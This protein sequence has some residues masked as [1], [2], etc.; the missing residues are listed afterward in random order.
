MRRHPLDFVQVSYSAVE[1]DV[2]ARILPLARDR[3]IAVVI[4]RPFREGAL[5][6][7]VKRRPLPA[8]ASRSRL[9]QLGRVPVEVHRVASGGRLRDSRDD[10]RRSR[11]R[12]HGRLLR[13]PARRSR[14]A[15]GWPRTSSSSD[16]RVVDV[17]ALGLPALFARAPTTAS[18]SSTTPT[19]GRRRSSRSRSVSQ[20]LGLLR[21]PRAGQGRIVAAILAGCWLWVAWAF[22]WRHYATI[23]WAATYFAGAF[24]VEALLLVVIGVVRNDLVVRID[25]RRRRTASASASC[26][27]RS[28]VQPL[29]G[30][31][32]GRGWM[33]AEVFGVAPDP[34]VSRDARLPARGPRTHGVDAAGSSRSSG[35]H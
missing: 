3:G 16:V 35:A 4:N 6:R 22:H 21:H 20:P 31:L 30:P 17:Y 9:R 18:S 5:I 1:R 25:R 29:I 7:S 34:T 24:A 11:P 8:W 12:E 23:N 14:C 32:V 27:S 10:E 33:Q 15:G 2:E 19:S 26:C 28:L 13:P